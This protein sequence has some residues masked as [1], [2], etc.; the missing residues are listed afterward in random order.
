LASQ[1]FRFQFNPVTKKELPQIEV[2]VSYLTPL[3]EISRPEDIVVGR[4]GLLI[5]F[6]RQSGVL[7]PQVAYELGWT[8]DEFLR[9]V[10][11]K[12]GL[13]ADTWKREEAQL[14]TF[15][16]EVFNESHEMHP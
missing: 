10:C 3:K 16:A 5:S 8:R 1:D 9:Q 13:P 2:E 11:R 14:Y 12:A 7:L 15:Q 4:D 6:G